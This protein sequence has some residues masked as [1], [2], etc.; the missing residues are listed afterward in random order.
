MSNESP[1]VTGHDSPAPSG[2]QPALAWAPDAC[3]LPTTERPL[4]GAE[5]RAAFAD[6]VT[7]AERPEPTRLRLDLAR[8]PEAAARVAGLATR[9]ADCCSF[10]TFTLA[11]TASALTLD[12]TVPPAHVPVLDALAALAPAGQG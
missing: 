2:S 3:T 5:F 12:I 1:G 7:R 4:R 9:E 10:F 6:L 8:G 11:V